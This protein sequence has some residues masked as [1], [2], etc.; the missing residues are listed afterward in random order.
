MVLYGLFWLQSTNT[1]PRR[2]AFAITAVTS[3]GVSAASSSASAFA[4]ADVRSGVLTV[5][6]R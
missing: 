3:R 2:R 1:R 4:Y 6:G 5:T